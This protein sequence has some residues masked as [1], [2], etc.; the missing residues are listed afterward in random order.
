MPSFCTYALI[1]SDNLSEDGRTAP[2][3]DAQ[4]L[5]LDVQKMPYKPCD[6]FPEPA[7]K[8]R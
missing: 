1:I 4:L 5:F 8:H 3:T 7:F 6:D 2:E